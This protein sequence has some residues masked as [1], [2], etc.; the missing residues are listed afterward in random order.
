MQRIIQ[1]AHLFSYDWF[2]LEGLTRFLFYSSFNRE[3]EIKNNLFAWALAASVA[4]HN[5]INSRY[6]VSKS[7]W[8]SNI[9]YQAHQRE[10]RIAARAHSL[11]RSHL[12]PE[13]GS[14]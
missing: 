4:R 5:F 7:D 3:T 11:E 8:E 12:R 14:T 1:F 13:L 9:I 6:L 2:W 10:N